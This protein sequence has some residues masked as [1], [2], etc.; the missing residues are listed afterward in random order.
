[1]NK[2][3][4]LKMAFDKAST[5]KEAITLAKEMVAFLGE[6]EIQKIELLPAPKP[7]DRAANS[8]KYWANKEIEALIDMT[9]D[10]RPLA[11]IASALRRTES[12]CKS[13]I[14]RINLGIP[15]GRPK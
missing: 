12:S 7:V 3:E 15:M 1:M 14:R 13:A 9:A 2:M 10:N 8:R 6:R 4:I 5:P 11:E